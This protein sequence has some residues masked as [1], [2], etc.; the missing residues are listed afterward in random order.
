M[1]AAE[2]RAGVGAAEVAP[3]EI[4]PQD[5][6]QV[7]PGQCQ[8]PG[9]VPPTLEAPRPP[10]GTLPHQPQLEDEIVGRTPWY[11][12]KPCSFPKSHPA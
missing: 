4:K 3:A 9:G 2:R 6:T 5:R 1:A 12:Y 10:T 7:A 11:K 8:C